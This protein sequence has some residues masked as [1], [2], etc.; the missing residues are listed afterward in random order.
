MTQQLVL[1]IGLRRRRVHGAR[2]PVGARQQH[3]AVHRL[4]RPAV[5]DEAPREEIEQ[6]GMRR[7]VAG[8]AK[9]V[10]RAH[11]AVAEVMFPEAVHHD[12]RGKWVVGTGD[13]LGDFKPAA[14]AADRRLIFSGD[15][16]QEASRRRLAE[17]LMIAANVDSNIVRV[18]VAGDGGENRSG[19]PRIA[20]SL[21]QSHRPRRVHILGR[22]GGIGEDDFV[23]RDIAVRAAIDDLE[24][25]EAA[26]LLGHPHGPP[27]KR[28]TAVRHD[29]LALM[30]VGHQC[31]AQ[32]RPL[33]QTGLGL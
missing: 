20:V 27:R 5:L 19:N 8:P 6:L 9:I 30:S 3:H 23:Y 32:R 31:E 26:D 29:V 15:H 28:T 25:T 12:A 2:H 21:W 22:L 11:Q 1:G 10:G 4:H 14:A 33:L 13:F 18:L 16:L 24:V 17:G 7:R